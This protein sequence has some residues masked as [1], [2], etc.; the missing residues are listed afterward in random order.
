M[1]FVRDLA[2]KN[3]KMRMLVTGFN[4]FPG[5]SFNPS[6][7]LL[8]DVVDACRYWNDVDVVGLR[9]ET[10]F[11]RSE[12]QL[13]EAIKLLLPDAVVIFG[14]AAE[15]SQILLE[16]FALNLDDAPQPDNVG[17]SRV[18]VPIRGSGPVAYHTTLPMTAMYADLD[19]ARVPVAYSSFAGTDVCNHVFYV[20][21]YEREQL[22]LSGLFGL[23]HVPLNFGET[24]R[25]MG[26]ES[27]E[28]QLLRAEVT[29]L[30]TIRTALL[31]RADLQ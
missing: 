11:A 18:N 26:Y 20:A 28:A 8:T 7:F 6:G 15:A 4:A 21:L 1:R 12:Q 13:T 30:H 25:W 22:G 27:V 23:I 3:S 14:A 24:G 10:A 5:V 19:S 9:L 16:R 29:C 31:R 17:D 2:N